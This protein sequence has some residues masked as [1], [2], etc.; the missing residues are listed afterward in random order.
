MYLSVLSKR[1]KAVI[2]LII[3]FIIA[4][5]LMDTVSSRSGARCLLQYEM[6]ERC[7]QINPTQ[8]I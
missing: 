4:L 2:S 6:T 1:G 5:V 3:D 8:S 7:T